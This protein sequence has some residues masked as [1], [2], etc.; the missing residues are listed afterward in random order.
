MLQDTAAIT[1]FMTTHARLLDRRRLD[2]ALGQD[3]PDAALAALA[4]YRNPDGGFGS[5]I[6]P[7]LRAP[8]SQ[9]VGALH[10]FEVFEDIA[11]A[12]SPMAKGLCD[13][14]ERTALP[15]GA[16]PFAL[17]GAA[18]AGTASLWAS[19]DPAT[20]SLH[21][22]AV[23]AGIALRVGRHDPAVAEHPWLR[24][25]TRYILDE[26]AKLTEPPHPIALRYI[27]QFLDALT[28][29]QPEVEPELRRLAAFVPPSA[30]MPV[31]GGT[32]EEAMRPLDFSPHPDRPLRALIDPAVIEA[33]LDRL[34]ADQR[35]DGGWDV[36]WA[37]WSPA[38]ALEW[39]GWATVRAVLILRANGRLR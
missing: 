34:E 13:W 10:A 12:T 22:T 4:A 37:T 1:D 15:G 18:S 35:A 39:R 7:D 5:A 31:A 14:L 6:E 8:T 28:D 38:G 32:A 9:P 19:A 26:T 25:A 17:A 23:V 27:L 29:R 11:P 3:D 2:L 30:T 36:D 21:M 16:L 20:P 24:A 33:D